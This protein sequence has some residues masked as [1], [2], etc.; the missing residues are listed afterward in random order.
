MEAGAATAL[1]ARTHAAVGKI[2]QEIAAEVIKVNET[3]DL[4]RV[5]T[6]L[7]KNALQKRLIDWRF[8]L[9][10]RSDKLEESLPIQGMQMAFVCE[11]HEAL[12][13]GLFVR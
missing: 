13:R 8:I 4:A 12:Q 1:L 10:T 3:V 11:V 2:R 7:F 6:L 9:M 5:K